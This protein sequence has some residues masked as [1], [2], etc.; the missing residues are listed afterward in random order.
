[1]AA[2]VLATMPFYFFMAHQVLT[3]MMLTAWLVWALYFYLRMV[4]PAPAR[5]AWLGFYLCVA[6]A[7]STKG[8]AALLALLAAVITSAEIDA[9]AGLRALRPMWEM[10]RVGIPKL[11]LVVHHVM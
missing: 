7:L 1:A 4:P 5:F 6:G 10:G 9:H 2:A 3:D 11:P 8:P